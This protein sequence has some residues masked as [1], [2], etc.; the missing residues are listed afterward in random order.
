MH[1]KIVLPKLSTAK[2]TVPNFAALFYKTAAANKNNWN[3]VEM[4][5]E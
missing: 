4:K 1:M 3:I 5:R 2:K